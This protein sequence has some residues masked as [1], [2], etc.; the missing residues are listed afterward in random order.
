MSG[1]YTCYNQG[2]SALSKVSKCS[3]T[4]CCFAGA[5][6]PSGI[7]G[8]TGPTG[9][10][11]PSGAT[12]PAGLVLTGNYASVNWSDATIVAANLPVVLGPGGGVGPD[13]PIVA[14]VAAGGFPVAPQVAAAGATV[15]AAG[16]TLSLN[17]GYQISGSVT[18]TWPYVAN[19]F[20]SNTFNM[21][22]QVAISQF[23]A[24]A[25]V[26]I[27]LNTTYV[28]NQNSTVTVTFSTDLV[29]TVGQIIDLVV[30]NTGIVNTGAA[31]TVTPLQISVLTSSLMVRY[32]GA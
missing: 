23:V 13:L 17:G 1:G 26:P 2:V 8:L 28:Y 10:T 18:L 24:A 9:P 3:P 14:T 22:F 11:G 4:A 31:P 5:T 7:G 19:Q 12:G 6:G 20:D 25:W 32:I 16:V 21:I 30:T 27:V 15:T 29:G